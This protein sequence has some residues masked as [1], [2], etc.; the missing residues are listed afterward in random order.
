MAAINFSKFNKVRM[1]DV[2]T[3]DFD[4]KKLVNLYEE[5]GEDEDHIFPVT[6]IYISTKS[7]F[8]DESPLIATDECYVNL[9][10]F[11]LDEIKAMLADRSVIA[12][13]NRGELGFTITKYYQKRFHKDCYKAIWCNYKES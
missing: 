1:F 13:V 10:Q 5:F 9:P 2:D 4:Y 7:E 8:D 6:A 3:S 11:Q 12:A